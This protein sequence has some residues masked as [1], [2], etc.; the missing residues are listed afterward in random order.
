MKYLGVLILLASTVMPAQDMAKVY[1][2]ATDG[3]YSVS[4]DGVRTK[5]EG[6][7]YLQQEVLPGRHSIGYQLGY[8]GDWAVTSPKVIAGQDY[9][10]V[11]SSAPGSGR[12]CSQLSSAQ[13]QLCLRAMEN[14]GG[15]DPCRTMRVNNLYP[16]LQLPPGGNL[17]PGGFHTNTPR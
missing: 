6:K 9:Y 14:S 2:I 7:H 13:G 10:F 17:V 11:F 3:S 4:V 8:F 12:M 16:S 1:L 15:T 5:V